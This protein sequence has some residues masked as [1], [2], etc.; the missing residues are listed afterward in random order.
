MIQ[1]AEMIYE[2]SKQSTAWES[3]NREKGEERERE[4][5]R[6]GREDRGEEREKKMEAKNEK[7]KDGKYDEIREREINQKERREKSRLWRPSVSTSFPSGLHG[8]ML[9]FGTMDTKFGILC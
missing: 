9:T 5:R 6:E 8:I 3:A 2:A 1:Q 7:R 4:E